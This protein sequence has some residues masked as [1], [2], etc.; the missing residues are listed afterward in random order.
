MKYFLLY[1]NIFFNLF[2]FTILKL[3]QNKYIK[4]QITQ[5]SLVLFLILL[6]FFSCHKEVPDTPIYVYL[7]G[8]ENHRYADDFEDKLKKNLSKYSFKLVI[9][10][11]ATYTILLNNLYYG[12]YTFVEDAPWDD[13]DNY[14]YSL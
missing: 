10:T 12:E 6:A 9:D 14:E 8:Y 3:L 13:C 11:A 7:N 5:I 4:K 1:Y 2:K